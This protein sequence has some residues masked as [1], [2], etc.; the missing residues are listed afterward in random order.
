MPVALS[1]RILVVRALFEDADLKDYVQK[2]ISELWGAHHEL[3]IARNDI[4]LLWA[5]RSGNFDLIIVFVNLASPPETQRCR[6][7][8]V[9]FRA[10]RPSPKVVVV[11]KFFNG[12]GAVRDEVG[13][14]KLLLCLPSPSDINGAIAHLFP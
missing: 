14:N 3:T 12:I 10:M 13:A 9:W 2:T 4:E 7:V 6:Q 11:S 1:L 8:A 5:M